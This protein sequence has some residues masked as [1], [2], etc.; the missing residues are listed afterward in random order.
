MSTYGK[1]NFKESNINYLNKDFNSLKLSLM[2][3]A[4][5]Y[6]PDTYRDFNETSPGMML[7]E[8]NAYVG[9]VLS[10]YIDKQY[11]EMLL[12][13]AEERRN[14]INMAKMFGY[15]VKP[16]VPAFVDL[17]F[18]S[19]VNAST[20]NPANVDYSTAGVFD[21]GIE[22]ASDVN[23]EIIFKTI[24]H[25]D[26]QISSSSDT[27]TIANTD[28]FGIANSYTLTRKVKAISATEKTTTFRI[29]APEKF[30][31]IT[32]PD[33]NVIDIVSCV[34]SNGNNWYEVDFLAQDRVSIE[35]HYTDDLTRVDAYTDSG[36]LRSSTAVPF[37]LSYI[38]TPK[39]FTR[40][41]NEDN[42]TSLIFGNGVLKDGQ[43]V[44][45]NY[46]DMEQVGIVIPGQMND[47]DEAVDPLLGNEYSTLGET[48][49]QT[50]LTV[51]YRVGGGLNSN[52]P[53]ATISTTPT[54]LAQNGNTSA[55]LTNV[56]NPA[57]AR[58]GRDREET[59]EIKEKAKAFFATQNRCVTKEDYEARI[60]NLPSKFGSIAKVYVT[61]ETNDL[62]PEAMMV[63]DGIDNYINTADD[64]LTDIGQVSGLSDSYAVQFTEGM[65]NQINTTISSLNSLKQRI[66]MGFD[67]ESFNN[68]MDTYMEATVD[69]ASEI[70]FINPNIQDYKNYVEASLQNLLNLYTANVNN[71]VPPQEA[72]FNFH[73]KFVELLYN[74][75][76]PS[77]EGPPGTLHQASFQILN[78]V[79]TSGTI[80][81]IVPVDND[82][83]VQT[84][85]SNLYTDLQSLRA[86]HQ[87]FYQ[88]L[89]E[90]LTHVDNAFNNLSQYHMNDIVPYLPSTSTATIETLN[91]Y[92]EL[93]NQ[94]R[95]NLNT[96]RDADFYI[97]PVNAYILGY[98]NNKNLV[99]NPHSSELGLA[100]SD[101]IPL[102]L[103]E[104]IST[105][106]SNFSILTDTI[107]L[108]DGYIVNFGVLF[109]IVA[110]KFANKQEVKLRCIEII[111]QYFRIEK[112]QFNQPINK[113]QLEYELMGV[114]GVRSIGH[115][116]LTQDYDYFYHEGEG[117]GQTLT[118]PTYT[119]SFS[120][121]GIGADLDGD[122]E[123]DGGFIIASG[124][125]LG[126][127]YKYD[128]ATAMSDDESIIIPPN[129]ATPTVF[130]LK[131]PNTNIKGRV[132]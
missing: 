91:S 72:L 96:L 6:F 2:N 81:Q 23:S 1:D 128:F 80:R 89:Q 62:S 24:E 15:K 110:E 44:D 70:P 120:N 30:K 26:F 66:Q 33:T 53:T 130:E 29:G 5:S 103:M 59:L 98:N 123:E 46:I 54:T 132:R 106:L 12:P 13:L 34:D 122:G 38:T 27:E 127:G 85:P 100:A 14:I 116:T 107:T 16:I 94:N 39:R 32:I 58:G 51:T 47:L 93:L 82:F 111:K 84:P 114:E 121:T 115:V 4:K 42:T 61:L 97:S 129:V 48:P 125:T 8:M 112:M 52:I 7:L 131:N 92:R 63:I 49:N 67:I 124:G 31:R 79:A 99:G 126:Y 108:Q 10:F 118:A 73:N 117:N 78:F 87:D 20:G 18:Q 119:Y 65:T 104:N 109:D 28:S 9:D 40:E 60:L 37:S 105:H 19:T 83:G 41:T 101:G 86:S 68:N 36:G 113:S 74:P 22:I 50:T 35:T 45:E 55:I 21:P 43:V 3:Y 64:A 75:L 56:S 95:P 11:Q 57:A 90:D 25:I 17:D 88:G 77:G 69:F 76:H 102:S 71:N